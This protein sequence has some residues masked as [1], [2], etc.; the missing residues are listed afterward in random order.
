MTDVDHPGPAYDAARAL[1]FRPSPLVHAFGLDMNRAALVVVHEAGLVEDGVAAGLARAIDLLAAE[2]YAGE[3]VDYLEFESRLAELVGGDASLIHLGRSRQDMFSA[4]CRAVLRAGILEVLDALVVLRGRL[5][6][7]AETHAGTVVPAYTHGVQAQPTT[8]GHYLLAVDDAMGR[9]F[10]RLDQAYARGN[11]SPLGAGALTT[12]RFALDR[13]LLAGLLGFDGVVE[14]SYAANHLAPT[15]AILEAAAGF[16]IVAVQVTQIVQD[17]HQVQAA[18]LPWL[19]LAAGPL[20]GISS[21]MP[22][23]RNPTALETLRELA[24]LVTGSLGALFTAAHNLHTGMPD[25]REVSITQLAAEPTRLLVEL[26]GDVLAALRVDRARALAE[27]ANDY[28]TM[29]ELA[30]LLH[31]TAGVSFRDGHRFASQL[32]DHGRAQALAPAD[33]GVDAAA[34]IYRQVT[35]QDFPLTEQRYRTALDPAAFVRS[36]AGLGGPQPAEL[37]RMLDTQ[38]DQLA[39]DAAAVSGHR[40]RLAA[41]AEQLEKRFRALVGG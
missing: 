5:L 18:P 35:G 7:L 4:T 26:F 24:S 17:V 25:I 31:D 19:T 14:N 41:A 27:C 34:A 21:M 8:F 36:R 20:T 16:G 11:V 40:G 10:A 3:W 28:S 29:T 32:A 6:G 1:L 33:I 39:N 2:P 30:D 12:S 37:A 15:D 23:K 9:G 13:S 38:R 22:Q